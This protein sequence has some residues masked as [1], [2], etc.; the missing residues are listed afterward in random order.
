MKNIIKLVLIIL[1]SLIFATQTSFAQT[2]QDNILN[3]KA[4][5]LAKPVYPETAKKSGIGGV[6]K[7]NVTVDEQGNVIQADAVSGEMLL[8]DAA[9]AAARAS[10]FSPNLVNSKAAKMS[11]ILV[12]NF[13][14]A[15][16]NSDDLTV[17][18][19][20]L[21]SSK[22]DF[23]GAFEKL[24]KSNSESQNVSKNSAENLCSKG[25]EFTVYNENHKFQWV[26]VDK[27]KEYI[28]IC[29]ETIKAN[30]DQSLPYHARGLAR[31][32]LIRGFDKPLIKT[33]ADAEAISA[34]DLRQSLADL[35]IFIDKQVVY[36]NKTKYGFVSEQLKMSYLAAGELMAVFGVKE[37]KVERFQSAFEQWNTG[38]KLKTLADAYDVEINRVIAADR[39]II[40]QILAESSKGT[41]SSTTYTDEVKT[42]YQKYAGEYAA[43]ESVYKTKVQSFQ[44]ILKA[45]QGGASPDTIKVCQSLSEMNTS[46][47]AMKNSF[48]KISSM[49][50]KG[51][52]NF[53]ANLVKQVEMREAQHIKVQ[54]NIS[55]V[56]GKYGCK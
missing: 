33:L 24:Q 50:T 13:D 53:D 15:S 47:Q 38:E 54:A 42:R 41:S 31:Y 9:L 11:G 23:W 10:K 34:E 19:E 29:D 5:S 26:S 3:G 21:K 44:E 40:N 37:E 52:L 48:A 2:T 49:K 36:N 17:F 45:Q 55:A 51:E 46:F 27:V 18:D 12:F 6:V 20:Y 25:L 30:P 39:E 1:V 28:K 43:L 7:I 35:Q 16:N 22:T 14:A 4:T 56:A 8:R 32:Y